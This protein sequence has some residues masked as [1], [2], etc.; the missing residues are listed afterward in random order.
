MIFSDETVTQETSRMS[1]NKYSHE[2]IQLVPS[3]CSYGKS[4][5]MGMF[6]VYERKNYAVQ[7]S[8]NLI[9]NSIS[10]SPREITQGQLFQR[11]H[12]APTVRLQLADEGRK[13]GKGRKSVKHIQ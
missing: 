10:R 7:L 9:N 6:D 1:V 11:F 13:E 2:T 4:P 3:H 5:E 8:R 12:R